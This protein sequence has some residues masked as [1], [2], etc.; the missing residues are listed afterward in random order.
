MKFFP[1]SEEFKAKFKNRLGARNGVENKNA[2]FRKV[3]SPTNDNDRQSPIVTRQEYQE[4]YLKQKEIKKII[5]RNDSEDDEGSSPRKFKDKNR[6][7]HTAEESDDHVLATPPRS[8]ETETH[9]SPKPQK[10]KRSPI[11]FDLKQDDDIKRKR[12]RSRDKEH[13]IISIRKSN[14]FRKFDNVPDCKLET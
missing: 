6:G 1:D 9:N 12:S 2:L 7:R 3:S 5:I 4:K 8:R 13:Q 11:T 14:E 10:R